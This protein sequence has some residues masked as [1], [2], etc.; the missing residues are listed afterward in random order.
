[1]TDTISFAEPQFLWLLVAPAVLL[2]LWAWRLVRHAH[3]RR[4]FQ[5]H[6]RLPVRERLT[7]FGGLL[8]WFFILNCFTLELVVLLAILINKN[9][10][11]L[12]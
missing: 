2:V 10:T 9:H 6:R 3:D 12:F 1:M 5:R 8:F 7:L 4:A 11:V